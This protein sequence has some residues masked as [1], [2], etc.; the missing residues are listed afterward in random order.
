MRFSQAQ[1][2]MGMECPHLTV[3]KKAPVNVLIRPGNVGLTCGIDDLP[4]LATDAGLHSA[5]DE[6][7]E[8]CQWSRN[9]SHFWK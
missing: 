3:H 1:H 6:R 7:W 4:A 9:D 2:Q 8:L 5:I